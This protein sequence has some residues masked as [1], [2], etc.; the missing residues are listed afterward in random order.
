MH[1]HLKLLHAKERR[2]SRLRC[3]LLT[4]GTPTAVAQRLNSVA[5]RHA[6]V[7]PARHLWQ[8][9]GWTD[10]TEARLGETPPFLSPAHREALTDWWLAKRGTPGRGR[11]NTPN[12]DI[13]SQAT[14]DD[15]EGLLLVEA[16][17][18]S[19]ELKSAGKRPGNPDNDKRIAAAIAEAN[20]LLEL[21]DPGWHLS[22]SVHYQLANRFAWA[23]KIAS[24]GVPVVLVYLA[25]PDA[26]EMADQGR[27][28][29]NAGDWIKTML[30]HTD[31]IVPITAWNRRL[32]IDGTPL[33][34][35]IGCHALRLPAAYRLRPGEN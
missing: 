11:A 25:F 29:A 14:I 9:K 20:T 34:A 1:E 10:V 5:R 33:Y 13:V 17:A 32:L 15:R 28:F 7:D 2:G 22:A 24:L 16:K 23:C 31:G 26:D 3:L 21:A 35:T 27:P 4:E 12:W 8:P 19:A 18:H 30:G 6:T